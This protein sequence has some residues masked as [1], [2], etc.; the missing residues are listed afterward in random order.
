MKTI[1]IVGGGILGLT[2][3]Y[4]LTG[5][6]FK[7][8]VLEEARNVGGL[9]SPFKIGGY[10][11]DRFYHVILMSDTHLLEL[12]ETLGLKDDIRWGVTKTGFFTDGRLYSMSNTL[13]FLSF[14]PL[15]MIDK[16]RLGMTIFYAS[17]IKSWERLE[18]IRV[19]DWLIRFSGKRTFEKIWLPLLK[20][21]LGDNYKKANAAFI[22]AI[23]A[24]MYAARRSGL[25][26]EMFGYVD[27]GYGLVLERFR[28]YLEEMGVWIAC[29]QAVERIST[30]SDGIE[31]TS[32]DGGKQAFDKVV[33][34]LP[35]TRIPDMCQ[36]LTADEEIR[37]R[38]ITYQ[39]IIC[40][41]LV[42]K[43]RLSEYYITNITD[44]DVP[45]TAVIEMTTLVDKKNFGGNTLIYLPKYLTDS[46]P[47]WE[48]EDREIEHEFLAALEKMYPDFK[49]NRVLNFKLSKARQVLPVTTLNYSKELLAPVTTSMENVYVVNS[50]QNVSGTMNINETVALAN[51]ASFEIAQDRS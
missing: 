42:L 49:E 11:W 50:A 29:S 46:D 25:K 33:L 51:K 41:V 36:D 8:S 27:G 24:R 12:L 47:F 45:F 40:G 23:I 19:T 5:M 39:G 21:K 31:I 7:V 2:L 6:G 32:G 44:R 30:H 37:S 38:N 22:W 3:A 1:G 20:S 14:P 13:E 4:R 28:H 18:K 26:Q 17:K 16:L 10:T 9:A 15:N 35:S 34:T 48:K 43:N